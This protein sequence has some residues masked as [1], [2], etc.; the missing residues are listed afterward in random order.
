MSELSPDILKAIETRL[1]AS[2]PETL[3]IWRYVAGLTGSCILGAALAHGHAN[4]VAVFKAAQLEELYASAK[5]NEAL[6]GPDPHQ[7][8]LQDK[9]RMELEACER[10]LSY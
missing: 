7:A 4:A 3:L 9:L 5:A 1:D 8:K 6:H 10:F 2:P